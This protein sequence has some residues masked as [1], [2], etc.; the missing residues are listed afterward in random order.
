MILSLLSRCHVIICFMPL[1]L[2]RH[3]LPR[4]VM[5]TNACI[6]IQHFDH[7]TP[8]SNNQIP[9]LQNPRGSKKNHLKTPPTP[10]HPSTNPDKASLSTPPPNQTSLHAPFLKTCPRAPGPEAEA[11]PD[12][13]EINPLES[14]PSISPPLPTKN[15]PAPLALAARELEVSPEER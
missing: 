1:C 8:I 9:G 4:P 14:T 7:S 11:E 13:I 12:P 5:I 3:T 6:S 2:C 15:A 10:A